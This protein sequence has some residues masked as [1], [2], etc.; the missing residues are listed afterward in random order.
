MA[1]DKNEAAMLVHLDFSVAFDTIDHRPSDIGI[2][3]LEWFQSYLEDRYQS[4]SIKGTTSQRVQL[5]HG[6]PQ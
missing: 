6:V 3:A 2:T 5:I 1:L 4:C